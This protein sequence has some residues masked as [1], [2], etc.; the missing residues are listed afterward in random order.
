MSKIV[1]G[2]TIYTDDATAYTAHQA[3]KHSVADYVKAGSHERNWLLGNPGHKG[4]FH[5]LFFTALLMRSL[6]TLDQI[7]LIEP[8]R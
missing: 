7:A 8:V 3:V 2:T 1:P 5:R 6:N 4:T